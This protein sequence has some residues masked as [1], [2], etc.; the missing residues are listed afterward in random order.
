SRMST[1]NM[2]HK[3]VMILVLLLFLVVARELKEAAMF[4]WNCSSYGGVCR[5]SCLPTELQF[6]PFGCAKDF[7]CCVS[8]I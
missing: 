3:Y 6:I 7:V 1:V 2:N 8:Y 5:S 4:P